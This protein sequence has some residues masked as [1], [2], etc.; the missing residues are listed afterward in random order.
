MKKKLLGSPAETQKYEILP[1]EGGQE[2]LEKSEP[3]LF[4]ESGA[5]KFGCGICGKKF[6]KI[7]SWK[8]HQGNL[9]H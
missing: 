6:T 2:E 7:K 4:E 1:S 3:E 8:F 5:K 9:Y